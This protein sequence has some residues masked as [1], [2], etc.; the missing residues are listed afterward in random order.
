[1]TRVFI[2]Q[3]TH[4]LLAAL[5]RGRNHGKAR[6]N[7][8]SAW[9]RKMATRRGGVSSEFNHYLGLCG[10][11]AAGKVYGGALP[12]TRVWDDKGDGHAPDLVLANGMGVSV[13]TRARRNYDFALGTKGMAEIEQVDLLVLCWPA[14]PYSEEAVKHQSFQSVAD[15]VEESAFAIEVVGHA[16]VTDFETNHDI[17]NYGY[18]PRLILHPQDFTPAPNEPLTAEQLL[19]YDFGPK[20]PTVWV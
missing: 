13:K 11:W 6:F 8:S 15:A 2:P 18:G 1:M 3:A 17:G 14:D 12:D 16:T 10:E 20:R 5:A 7:D 19:A 4:E 9:H